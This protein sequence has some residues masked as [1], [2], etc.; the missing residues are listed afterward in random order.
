MEEARDAIQ[1]R[2][3]VMPPAPEGW[4]GRVNREKTLERL[5]ADLEELNTLEYDAA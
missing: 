3:Q 4:R 1:G 2:V 5:K